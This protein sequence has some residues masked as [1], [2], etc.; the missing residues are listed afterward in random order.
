MLS[1]IWVAVTMG[2]PKEKERSMMVFWMPGSSVKVD[3]DAQVAAG[4]HDSVGGSQDAVD[5]VHTLTVLDLSDDA[6]VGVVLV[7][8]V[9]DLVHVLC[10][11]HK[12]KQR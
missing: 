5:V 8:Q 7:Q 12:G 10:S 11:A 2:L 3:L 4:H 6:D 9:A 1:S